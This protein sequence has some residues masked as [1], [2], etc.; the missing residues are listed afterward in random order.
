MYPLVL[1]LVFILGSLQ[2]PAASFGM[3]PDTIPYPTYQ[4]TTLHIRIENN[5]LPCD[6]IDTVGNT[7]YYW[8]YDQNRW[9]AKV[10]RYY[11][12]DFTRIEARY[13][14]HMAIGPDKDL[15]AI[16]LGNYYDYS[17]SGKLLAV[18]RFDEGQR[19]GPVFYYDRH[20]TLRQAG[21]YH[22]GLKSGLWK[23]FSKSGRLKYEVEYQLPI[24]SDEK[25]EDDGKQPEKKHGK[26]GFI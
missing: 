23:Y 18:I 5:V 11:D 14:A 2:A 24:G 3:Q 12:K 21:M 19:Q 16:Y 17:K 20:G 22:K 10:H 9:F 6:S 13:L 4:N 26:Q 8:F 25:H 1:L 7:V 15:I